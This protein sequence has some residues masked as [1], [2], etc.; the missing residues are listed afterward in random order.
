MSAVAKSFKNAFQVLTPVREYG[1]GKRVTRVIWDKYAEPSF[2]E[3]VRIRPSPDLKHGK[4]FGRFTFR[5]K[6]DPQVK[7]M[8]G[9]LKKDWS[10]WRRATQL[11]PVRLECN[12]RRVLRSVVMQVDSLRED[13]HI[14]IVLFS[15]PQQ[16]Q[17]QHLEKQ[18]RRVKLLTAFKR[19][20]ACMDLGFTHIQL[21]LIRILSR[22]G[23]AIHRSLA[24]ERQ[25]I[26][27]ATNSSV[28]NSD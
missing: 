19:N 12:T 23:S 3:V 15:V 24:M 17:R 6:T 9:V 13:R 18:T 21:R 8:N 22:L 28:D 25:R 11:L 27:N 1:V 10:L 14:A 2:W 7:R 26:G 16:Y 4:V 20:P 5:G